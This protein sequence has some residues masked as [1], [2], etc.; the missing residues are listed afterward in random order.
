MF[1]RAI[2]S[3]DK[4]IDMPMSSKA[5]YFLLGMEADDEGF[6]SARTVMRIHAATEDDLNI[7]LAKG[8]V[9]RFKSGVVVITHWKKNNWLDSRRLRRTEYTEEKQLLTVVDGNYLLSDGLARVEES[10]IEENR[11][12]ASKEAGNT[13]LSLE[14]RNE[15]MAELRETTT[16]LTN[17]KKMA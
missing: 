7:L 14:Q 2:S 17:S 3:N 13:E 5:L 9:I 11:K 10:R 12:E 4:F 16:K 1:D 15:R 6:V 8:F